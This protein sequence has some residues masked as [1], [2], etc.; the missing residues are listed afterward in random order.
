MRLFRAGATISVVL[1]GL[2]SVPALAL[3]EADVEPTT[4]PNE[5]YER[6]IRGERVD[7]EIIYL[8]PSAP[9]EPDG[10]IR[11]DVPEPDDVQ[12]S[13]SW[14]TERWFWVIFFG[15]L[16]AFLIFVI[17]KNSGAVKVS[18]KATNEQ[19]RRKADAPSNGM[20]IGASSDQPIDS[21]LERLKSM[22]DRR[23][24]LILLVS[25]ALELAAEKNNIR[26]GRAQT[27]RDV[28]RVL[29]KS[30]TH[31]AVIRRLVREAEIVHFGG[32]DV[33][34]ERWDDCLAAARPIFAGAG[35]R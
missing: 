22:A 29:P 9:F 23:E 33:S 14:G 31:F 11:I 13:S 28:V 2:A 5:A 35:T 24:A 8:R 12:D 4:G 21:F 6:T 15:V 25:R 26:L 30:W 3:T 34:E 32:R 19:S 1:I 20:T 27:A 7:S 17:V 16:L 10:D 18:F